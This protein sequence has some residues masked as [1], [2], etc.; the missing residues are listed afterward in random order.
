MVEPNGVIG[1]SWV[2]CDLYFWADFQKVFGHF[3]RLVSEG[4]R[5]RANAC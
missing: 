2:Y 5:I 3:H 1:Q 4:V